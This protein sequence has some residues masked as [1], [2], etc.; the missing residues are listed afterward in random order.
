MMLDVINPAALCFTS[1]NTLQNWLL[2]FSL[3]LHALQPIQGLCWFVVYAHAHLHPGVPDTRTYFSVVLYC[4]Q[5]RAFAVKSRG[6]MCGISRCTGCAN[7]PKQAGDRRMP[8]SGSP[9]A[10]SKPALTMIRSGAMSRM[11]GSTTCSAGSCQAKQALPLFQGS[12]GPQH[13]KQLC[14]TSCLQR[15]PE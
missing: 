10:A 4:P 15:Y 12:A 6:C 2:L 8:P 3:R 9:S 7:A 11:Y 14:M 5:T 13:R 1:G